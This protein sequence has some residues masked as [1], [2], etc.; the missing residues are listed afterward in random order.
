MIPTLD[1]VWERM[2]G[3]KW[4]DVLAFAAVKVA[5]TTG[6]ERISWGKEAAHMRSI[7]IGY[8]L[9]RNIS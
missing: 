4:S 6:D 1:E 8:D 2:T 5:T 7:R 3:K 9:A